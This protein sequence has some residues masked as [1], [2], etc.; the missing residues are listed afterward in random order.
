MVIDNNFLFSFP[1][2]RSVTLLLS[3]LF[4]P[5][6]RIFL[7]MVIDNNFL[8]SFPKGRPVF[9]LFFP[10]LFLSS[11]FKRFTVVVENNFLFY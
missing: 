11:I 6:I 5:P 8:F 7:H 3:L 9:L 2:D 1:K 10:P 4:F